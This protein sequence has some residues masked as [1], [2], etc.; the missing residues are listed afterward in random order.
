MTRINSNLQPKM[1]I[2]Y[3][4][5][6]EG[7]LQVARAIKSAMEARG[8]HRTVMVDLMAESHP[9][10]NEVTRR[11]YMKSYT[12][13]P[14][15]YGWMYDFT[16]P[17]KHDS[18]FGGLLHSFGRDKIKRILAAEQPDV[19]VHT[20][21]SFALPGLKKRTNLH[22]PSYAVVTD[23]D[24]HR[25]WVHPSI[26]RYY[27]ATED[28]KAEL[29]Q[30]GIPGG[31]VTVSGI[32]L[33][34]GFRAAAPS[35]EL[36]DRFGLRAARPVVLIMA[37]AEG[38]MPDLDRIC[39]GLLQDSRVQIALVCGRNAS[40]KESME[41][42]YGSRPEHRSRLRVY[43]YVEHIHELMALSS[44]L[45]TKPGGVTLS[46]AIAAGLPLFTY[47]P[48]PGQEKQNALYLASKGAASVAYEPEELTGQILQLL[49]EPELLEAGRACVRQLQAAGSAADRLVLDVL[50]NYRI[51]VKASNIELDKELVRA[52]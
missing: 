9:W 12:H 24:L 49:A 28:L 29:V 39:E 8:N 37:G 41:K 50:S 14:S 17:M 52:Y 43:G 25:R 40:L 4:S 6:G 23:F 32:P 44:C 2:L 21:P 3:A 34:A 48:V 51:M 45:V 13:M 18:L 20:F 19:V 11:F 31:S 42:R 46:E 30:L 47:R 35:P 38:V 26:E 1:L 10:L 33:K 7:H 5:Y 27:V 15:L 36:Y 22:P 16:K